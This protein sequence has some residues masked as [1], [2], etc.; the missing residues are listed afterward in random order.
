ME[1]GGAL[2]PFVAGRWYRQRTICKS[3]PKLVLY[4]PVVELKWSA[5]VAIK[6]DILYLSLQMTYKEE[7]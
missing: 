3:C 6:V 5:K 2:S 4:L 1:E 7:V